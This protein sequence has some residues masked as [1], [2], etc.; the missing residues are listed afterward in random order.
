MDG[1]SVARRATDVW[2]VFKDD[3]RVG[4]LS[5]LMFS[6]VEVG[7]DWHDKTMWSFKAKDFVQL[8]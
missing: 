4:T 5:R 3:K 1:Y 8:N 6:L 2:D 7:W